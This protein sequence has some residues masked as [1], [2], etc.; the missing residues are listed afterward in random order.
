MPRTVTGV[1]IGRRT[2]KFLRGHW[3][4]NTFH[5][6]RF[7]VSHHAEGSVA[8]AWKASE[9]D[10]KLGESRVGLTGRDVNIRYT[11]V[12]RVPDWQL[13]KLMRF[14]VEEIG[15][16]SGAEVAS[17]FNVL[18]N[19]PEV[20]GEDVVLLAMARESLLDEHLEG[21]TALGGKIDAF[22]PLAIALYN[23]WLRFGSIEDQTVLLANIGHEN[24]DVI[25][26]RGPDLLF[27]RNLSGGS[28]L[29]D[30]S[31]A[32]RFGVSPRKAEE[33]KREFATLDTGGTFKDGNQ[34]KASRAAQAAAGQLLSLLQSTVMFCKSQVN[35]TGLRVDKVLLCGGGSALKGLPRYLQSALN[36]P[37]ELFEP[38]GVV[39]T[40]KLPQEDR[41]LFEQH[42][43]EAV[44]VLGLA[45]MASDPDSY[46]IE[47][48]P[49][50]VAAARQFVQGTVFL[51]LA[52]V[53]AAGFLGYEIGRAHV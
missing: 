44:A 4:D 28:S 17:D 48:L 11:R 29:F 16:Q 41:E 49:R 43:L 32:E 25:L 45:T 23:A 36:V 9:L 10:F 2:T 53:L 52:G 34:E 51:I 39:D 30:T 12:P 1:D 15:G 26:V 7:A 6:T 27:A 42:A 18:P 13:R 46:S 8:A 24:L 19:L 22:T 5:A 38:L 40:T 37:V 35:L 20:E 3:K 31:I 21:L 50:K 14:E 47:I 33:L